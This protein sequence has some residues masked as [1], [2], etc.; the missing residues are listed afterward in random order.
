MILWPSCSRIWPGSNGS[1]MPVCS[2][3]RRIHLSLLMLMGKIPALPPIV[4][5]PSQAGVAALLW[6]VALHAR[7]QVVHGKQL[8]VGQAV[9]LGQHQMALVVHDRAGKGFELAAGDV[10]LA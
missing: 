10:V 1:I 3:M 7:H 8:R 4:G 6:N 5:R 2:A 9:P